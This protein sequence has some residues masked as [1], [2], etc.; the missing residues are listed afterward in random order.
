MDLLDR[1]Y[2]GETT[3]RTLWALI[4]PD[5]WRL[6]LSALCFIIK[7]SPVWILPII[8]A[9]IIDV[10]AL[11]AKHD[12]RRLWTDGAIML[13]LLIQN[14]PFEL[15]HVTQL[16]KVIR[17]V[18]KDLRGALTQRLQQLAI[19]FHD[20]ARTGALQ[21]K[22]LRDVEAIEGL[23][24]YCFVM[25]LNGIT[26]VGFALG[27][28]IYNRAHAMALFYFVTIPVSVAVIRLFHH[29]IHTMNKSFRTR[30]EAMAARIAEMISMI[31]ITRAHGA[32]N[33]EIASMETHLTQVR[34]SG[35]KLDL[36]NALFGAVAWVSFQVPVLLSLMVAGYLAFQGRITPGEITMYSSY[37]MMILGSV[38]MILNSYPMIA[39][40]F[41]SIRSIGEILESPDIERNDGKKAVDAVRGAFAF[42]RVSFAYPSGSFHAVQ[43]ISMDVSPGEILA[44]VGESGAGKSTLMALVI[45]FHRPTAGR[46]LLDGQDMETLDLRSYRQFLAVVPQQTLLFSGSMRDNIA[47]GLPAVPDDKV[48]QVVE[49]ANLGDLVGKLPEGLNTTVGERG[50]RLSG[51]ERQRVSIARAMIRDPR[52]I[53][54]DEA[55][56][57]LDAASEN[58]VQQALQRLIRGRTTFIV[59]HRLSTIRH[60][61]RIAVLKQGRLVELGTPDELLARDGEFAR[62]RRFQI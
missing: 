10:V 36:L 16:S 23:C 17:R 39:R 34:D 20:R 21:S 27:V 46:I 28:T 13:A 51:G 43:D 12:L 18:E 38:N 52:V 55:T 4:R 50:V 44:V 6:A 54:L 14:I 26:S 22:M 8:M 11:P 32:E 15:V 47:Y 42:D 58:L 19:A 2:R 30:I 1:K 31:P 41:E 61:D 35:L 53:I 29:R 33:Y 25:L 57:S 48:Q 62:L 56:S 3:L 9:D 24:R 37:F 60:A 49:A 40:G 7:H 45:G 5:A 59:A